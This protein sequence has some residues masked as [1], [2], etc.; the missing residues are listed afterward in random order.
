MR[1]EGSEQV[2]TPVFSQQRVS[3][4]LGEVVNIPGDEVGHLALVGMP[5]TLLDDVQFRRRRRQ[6]FHV[7]PCAIKIT[8]P[9]GSCLG[10]AEAIPDEEPRAPE[11]P[12]EPLEQGE[13]IVAGA[14]GGGERNIA[15]QALTPGRDGEGARHREASR[16]GPHYHGWAFVPWGAHVRRTVGWSMQPL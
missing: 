2:G 15:S 9:P 4:F 6:A 10:S 14:V 8:E 11:M 12:T 7:S 13:S 16:D 3:D 1:K 5:P